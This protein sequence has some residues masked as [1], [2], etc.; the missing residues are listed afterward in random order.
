MTWHTKWLFNTWIYRIRYMHP[1]TDDMV[2]PPPTTT[3][4]G[5]G[6]AGV[7]GGGGDGFDLNQLVISPPVSA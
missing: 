6:T 4:P 5:F 2:S 1:R 3:G 7:C